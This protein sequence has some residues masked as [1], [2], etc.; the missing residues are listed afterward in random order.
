L[1]RDPLA[2]YTQTNREFGHY[3][4]IR[5]FPGIHIYLLTHPDAV[6]HVLQKHHKN[7]RKPDFF[8][9]TVGLLTGK[10]I[11]LPGNGCNPRE[12]MRLAGSPDA[13]ASGGSC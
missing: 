8:N 1:Q 7:Y 2:L 13:L 12:E 4:R 6:E 10:G 3:A 9:G 5:A 11:R